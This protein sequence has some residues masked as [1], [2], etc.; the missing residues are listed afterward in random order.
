MNDS[1]KSD[2][3]GTIVKGFDDRQYVSSFNFFSSNGLNNE[4]QWRREFFGE[5]MKKGIKA[6]FSMLS[7]YMILTI[8]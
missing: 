6:S 7:D 3:I 5:S 2:W 1:Q 4:Y 8:Q